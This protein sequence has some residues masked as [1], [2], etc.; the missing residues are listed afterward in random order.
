MASL[1]SA[2]HPRLQTRAI[3]ASVDRDAPF[4]SVTTPLIQSTT[5]RQSAIGDDAAHTYSRASN[6]TVAALEA[7]LAAFEGLPYA[8]A[9]STGMSAITTL[10]LGTLRSG[11][12]VVCGNVV[13]GGTYRLLDQILRQFG[14]ATTFVDAS[15]AEAVRAA[16]RPNTR[17]VIVE[18]PANPTLDVC[19]VAAL[20]DVTRDTDTLLVVDNTFLTAALQ[21]VGAL[22]AD[23]VVYSTTKYIEGHN[24][25]VG[26]AVLCKDEV[27]HNRL[28]FIRKSLGTIQSP[29]NAW[30]TIRGL[31]TLPLRME[32]HSE[33]ALLVAQWLESRDEVASVSYPFLKSSAGYATAIRQQRAGGGMIAF[34]LKSGFDGAVTFCRSL[35]CAI[36]A[37]N[38]GAVESIVT[39]PASMTH[40][41]VDPAE[42]ERTGITDGLIRVSIGLEDPADL[43]QDFDQAIQRAKR[44]SVSTKPATEVVS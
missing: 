32:R 6:P 7:A 10:L 9:F 40:A 2:D 1:P 19:D 35:Q 22:G 26:G 41:D 33:N 23:V 3:H 24:A 18:T 31:K 29:Q 14:V 12:H 38:L 44:S 36:L 17:H 4:G 13:Y 42:R 30:L 27:L 16:L 34:E 11:D 20:A 25:T 5:F 28:D 15:D 37:E 8:L 21:D 43:I 39:H